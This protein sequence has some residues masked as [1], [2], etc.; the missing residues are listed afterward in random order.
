VMEE[1]EVAPPGPLEIRVKVV[2]TSVCRSDVSAWQ[3]KVRTTAAAAS[4][5]FA[6]YG[7]IEMS[8]LLI[9]LPLLGA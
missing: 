5:A 7:W 2:S 6:S 4:V 9:F 8:S 1:V 3:S